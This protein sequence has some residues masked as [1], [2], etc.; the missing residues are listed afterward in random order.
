MHVFSGHVSLAEDLLEVFV[1][2]G[3]EVRTVFRRHTQYHGISRQ[4]FAVA[5]GHVFG[6]FVHHAIHGEPGFAAVRQRRVGGATVGPGRHAE[7][8]VT[9]SAV[10]GGSE[11]VRRGATL[12]FEQHVAPTAIRAARGLRHCV[13][14]YSGE[15]STEKNPFH[16]FVLFVCI[17]MDRVLAPQALY[18]TDP[19]EASGPVL[20]PAAQFGV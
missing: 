12:T 16:I 18:E 7:R 8:G 15:E 11:E 10:G 17:P 3:S 19:N 1:S 14:G 2:D 5:F 4:R 13:D 9:G 6:Q 20:V